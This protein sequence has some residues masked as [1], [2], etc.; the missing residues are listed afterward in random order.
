MRRRGRAA[1][2]HARGR[3][4]S[5][6][7]LAA[8]LHE[9][10]PLTLVALRRGA[11]GAPIALIGA[12]ADPPKGSAGSTLYHFGAGSI[13][14]AAPLLSAQAPANG[15]MGVKVASLDLVIPGP[16]AGPPG[17]DIVLGPADT[18]TLSIVPAARDAATG[19]VNDG[20]ATTATLPASFDL[21]LAPAGISVT[22][23]ADAGF[24]TLGA[25]VAL[26][27]GPAGVGW[28]GAAQEIV[29][30]Y[31]AAQ[32]ATLVAAGAS[33]S[34]QATTLAGQY[35]LPVAQAAPNA[36]GAATTGGVPTLVVSAGLSWKFGDHSVR[37]G[38]AQVLAE[39][40]AL[41]LRALVNQRSFTDAFTM[42]TA[43]ARGGSGSGRPTSL[44]FTVPRGAILALVQSAV[45]EA[46][47]VFGA[48]MQAA[49][50]RPVTVAGTPIV[51]DRLIADYS[52]VRAPDTTTLNLLGLSRPPVPGVPLPVEV[53]VIENALLR[54]SGVAWL[55]AAMTLSGTQAVAGLM[56][57]GMALGDLLPTLPDPYISNDGVL[58]R[59]TLNAGLLA[60]IGWANPAAAGIGF[61]LL[62]PSPQPPS[63]DPVSALQPWGRWEALI[64]VSGR[65]D[66]VGVFIETRC[67]GTRP[68][69]WSGAAAAG[70]RAWCLHPAAH[71]VGGGDYRHRARSRHR[72]AGSRASPVVSA[73]FHQ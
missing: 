49:I 73:V 63:H 38:P 51:L 36:L 56:V 22:A 67:C 26:S 8:S 47:L 25:T 37:L 46:R 52:V 66:Q 14:I 30:G 33:L 10:D 48:A 9:I 40:G 20:T 17:A 70:P 60:E 35:R 32:P 42:W 16:P 50:D 11:G 59:P 43:P 57:A 29:F 65:A 13:W 39:Q 72:P 71:L 2:S 7:G 41:G 44:A 53:L 23:L 34:G 19:F 54:T 18:A 58:Q 62:P 4:A 3:S 45:V 6:N 64:D 12:P 5:T 28:D 24:T 31:G 15:F 55:T 69:R 1:W 27:G 68:D 21:Q 61:T